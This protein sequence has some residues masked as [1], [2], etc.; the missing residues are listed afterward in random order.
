MKSN[1]IHIRRRAGVHGWVDKT[2]DYDTV[3]TNSLMYVSVVAMM[4]EV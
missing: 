4:T 3:T 2:Q 1:K